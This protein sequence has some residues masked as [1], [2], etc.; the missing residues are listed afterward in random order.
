[1]LYRQGKAAEALAR[2][3]KALEIAS[4][5][6]LK[7]E[8]AYGYMLRGNVHTIMGNLD[9]AMSDLQRFLETSEELGDLRYQAYAHNNLGT[10]YH[11]K[12]DWEQAIFHYR[13]SYDITDKI[14]AIDYRATVSNNLG[15]VYLI[16]GQLDEAEESFKTCLATWRRTGFQLG[17][18]LSHR[19]LGQIYSDRNAWQAAIEHLRQSLI[20]FEELGTRDGTVAEVYRLLAE[21]YIGLDDL[22]LAENYCGVSLHIAAAEDIKLVIGNTK[23]VLGRIHRIRGM[24]TESEAALNESLTLARE[25]GMRHEEG[26]ALLEMALLYRDRAN[27]TEGQTFGPLARETLEQARGIFVELGADGDLERVRVLTD[28]W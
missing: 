17:V 6:G 8:M 16:R 27:Q 23:R 11:Y 7:P 15:E 13:Q 12:S 4:A 26:Q 3:Q 18:A 19:N 10:I 24:W 28:G 25:L 9:N 5:L 22:K 20:I 14:G 21:V 1:M 2:C